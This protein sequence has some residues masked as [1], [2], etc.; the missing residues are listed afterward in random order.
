MD[1]F[2]L[3]YVLTDAGLTVGWLDVWFHGLSGKNQKLDVQERSWKPLGTSGIISPLGLSF[4][5]ERAAAVL[6][7]KNSKIFIFVLGGKFDSIWKI[8]HVEYFC[9][10]M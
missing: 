6:Q 1:F 4:V 5:F 3:I 8:V 9:I 7:N 10:D 2:C